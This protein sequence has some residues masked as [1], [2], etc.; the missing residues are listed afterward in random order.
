MLRFRIGLHKKDAA[1]LEQIR[2]F[3]GAGVFTLNKNDTAQ[4]SFESIKD[5][6]VVINH[7]E[8]Y[9]LI[10]QKLADYLLFKQVFYLIKNKDHLTTDGLEKIVALKA[11]VNLGLPD[12]LK[13]AFPLVVPMDRSVVIDQEVRD[14]N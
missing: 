2:E 13:T 9:P 11:S 8:N 1:L 4:I 3:F 12:S 14:P 6:E 7:F 5:L 10:T